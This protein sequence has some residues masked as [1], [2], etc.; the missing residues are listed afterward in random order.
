MAYQES[1]GILEVHKIKVK[2]VSELVAYVCKYL[3]G[4]SSFYRSS[5][6]LV[7]VVSDEPLI[8]DRSSK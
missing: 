5:G 7:Y 8:E 4:W 2:Q 6:N 1:F 3:R